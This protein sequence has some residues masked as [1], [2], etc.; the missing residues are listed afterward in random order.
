MSKLR[1]LVF[2]P[3]KAGINPPIFVFERAIDKA[4][5]SGNF[6]T[7]LVSVGGKRYRIGLDTDKQVYEGFPVP[8]FYQACMQLA[9]SSYAKAC[10]EINLN[11]H[12]YAM[13]EVHGYPL[14]AIGTKLNWSEASMRSFNGLWSG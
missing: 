3:N 11:P 6:A 12:S 5:P 1:I 9:Y 4:R 13:W 7:G 2:A 8:G 10:Q 14:D